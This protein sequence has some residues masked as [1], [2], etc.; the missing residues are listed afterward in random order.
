MSKGKTIE[1][2]HKLETAKAALEA[3]QKDGEKHQLLKEEE[4]LKQQQDPEEEAKITTEVI[5][6]MKCRLAKERRSLDNRIMKRS[7]VK[8][9]RKDLMKSELLSKNA[10]RRKCEL[11]RKKKSNFPKKVF[12]QT[13]LIDG[14]RR[15]QTCPPNGMEE[16]IRLAAARETVEAC[17]KVEEEARIAEEKRLAKSRAEFEERI[18]KEKVESSR[19]SEE[20]MVPP[21]AG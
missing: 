14:R 7:H 15:S 4:L 19:T 17:L 8:W 11:V 2:D 6:E 5:R 16:E 20:T 9:N 21:M 18:E 1:E 12:S 13:N 3:C 10:W